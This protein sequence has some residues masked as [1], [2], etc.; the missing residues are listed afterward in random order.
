M[1]NDYGNKILNAASELFRSRGLASVTMDDIAHKLGVSKKTIYET[2]KSKDEIV[3]SIAKIFITEQRKRYVDMA[4]AS[5]A[6][7]EL[8]LLFKH[9]QDLFESLH[10]KITHEIQKYYP[11]IWAMIL[12]HKND[13]LL[14]KIVRNLI[15]GIQK[16]HYQPDIDVD[17][18]A[19]LILQQIELAYNSFHF[20]YAKYPIN[21][22]TEQLLKFYLFGIVTTNAHKKY[23]SKFK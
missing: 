7:E 4:T 6:I 20:P 9:L 11:D 1:E 8:L 14:E 18:T 19:K 15:R 3:S 21:K 2:Y 10:P 17:F 5:N 12:T 22:V 13:E 23:L 16:G